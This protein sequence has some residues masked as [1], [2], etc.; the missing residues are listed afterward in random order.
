MTN[1]SDVIFT[2]IN[3]ILDVAKLEAQKV[4]LINRTFDLIVLIEN[5]IDIFAEQAGKKRIELVLWF[6]P[7]GLPRYVKSDPE[8]Y[9]INVDNKFIVNQYWR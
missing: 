2:V 9:V 1:A 3:D 4:Q 7:D 6:E 8:R 5:T